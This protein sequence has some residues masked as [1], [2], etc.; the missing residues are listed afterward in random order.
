MSKLESIVDARLPE[1]AP[2][3]A[4]RLSAALD[5]SIFG[6]TTYPCGC[7][8]AVDPEWGILRRVSTCAAHQAE[9][10][11]T[12]LQHYIDMGCIVD[13]VP[14]SQKYAGE[15]WEAMDEIGESLMPLGNPHGGRMLEIGSGLSLYA[16]F[17]M[18]NWYYEGIEPDLE[19]ARWAESAFMV[20]ISR[21][22]IEDI[23][24]KPIALW[25]MILAAHV[26]E[27][28]GDAPATMN[29]VLGMLAPGGR[30]ILI[31][32][33]GEDD[34]VN[35]DHKFF[36]T[37]ATLRSTL[38]RIGFTDVRMVEKQIVKHERFIYCSAVKP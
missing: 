21:K 30:L 7:V 11:K 33:N 36:F 38:E 4:K 13:G 27:H 28:L 25:D 16:P 34:P 17:F 24:Q 23:Q 19:A 18:K 32:P 10:G 20:R 5:L 9:G 3:D 8:N 15:L 29:K 1:N 37:Q 6:R 22:R 26:F 31:V 14:Q 35:P 12:G 2:E